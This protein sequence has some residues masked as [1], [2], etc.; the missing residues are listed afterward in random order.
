MLRAALPDKGFTAHVIG[1]TAHAVL[2]ALSKARLLRVG[3]VDASLELILPLM[4][5]DLFGQ[6]RRCGWFGAQGS[7]LRPG[8]RHEPARA[9]PPRRERPAMALTVQYP[10]H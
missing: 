1:F 2:E 10:V 6:V 5:A 7:G 8:G 4:E 3:D 9:P